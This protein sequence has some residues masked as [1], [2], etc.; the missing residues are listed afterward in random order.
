MKLKRKTKLNA[1]CYVVPK[2]DIVLNSLH[3]NMTADE[4]IRKSKNIGKSLLHENW[5]F[6]KKEPTNNSQTLYL[7]ECPNGSIVTLDQRL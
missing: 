7:Y 1:V 6:V 3:M 4:Y 2:I 5:V